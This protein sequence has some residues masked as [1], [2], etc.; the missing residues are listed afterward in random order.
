[1]DYMKVTPRHYFNGRFPRE[2][3]FC[4][5]I[6]VLHWCLI[7]TSSSERPEVFI[8]FLRQPHRVLSSSNDL[9]HHTGTV[10]NI[11]RM[12]MSETNTHI[13]S[14]PWVRPQNSAFDYQIGEQIQSWSLFS[15]RSKVYKNWTWT[16]Q[17]GS[18]MPQRQPS[19]KMAAIFKPYGMC[20]E[21]C[22]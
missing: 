16:S 20:L 19:L 22:P 14:S 17:I 15:L 9:H 18:L 5:L 13:T 2:L 21:I 8:C 3:E 7:C 12:S 10:Q 1:M 11:N 4:P 6:F